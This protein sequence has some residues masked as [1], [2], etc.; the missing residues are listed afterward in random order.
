MSFFSGAHIPSQEQSEIGIFADDRKEL[1]HESAPKRELHASLQVDRHRLA[2]VFVDY[3]S[4][5][6][7]TGQIPITFSLGS[8]ATAKWRKQAASELNAVRL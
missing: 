6:W 2:P 1:Y 3:P 4:Y 7:Y 8:E 5:C